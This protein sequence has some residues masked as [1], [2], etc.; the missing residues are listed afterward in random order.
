MNKFNPFECTPKMSIQAYYHQLVLLNLML[1]EPHN[2]PVLSHRLLQDV[3]I[4]L[5]D[6]AIKARECT[7]GVTPLE[8]W[9]IELSNI[10]HSK[11]V[12]RLLHKEWNAKLR[13]CASAS[14]SS[15]LNRTQ[16]D[17]NS[18]ATP[19][20]A[21]I[22]PIGDSKPTQVVTTMVPYCTPSGTTGG[23]WYNHTH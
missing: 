8:V 5:I 18:C 7:P 2:K 12:T 21:S 16:Y 10:E 20:K 4:C 6:Y 13:N 1:S 9:V 3:P 15:M 17:Q 11:E 19:A 14:S 23:E 22:S